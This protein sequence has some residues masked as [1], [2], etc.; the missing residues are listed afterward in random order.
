[1]R[2]QEDGVAVASSTVRGGLFALRVA[3]TNHRTRLADIDA[4]VDAVLALGAGLAQR[5]SDA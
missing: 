3:I 5:P 4:F 2:V 1:M